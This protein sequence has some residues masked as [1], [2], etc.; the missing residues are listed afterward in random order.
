MA[1]PSAQANDNTKGRHGMQPGAA[2]SDVLAADYRALEHVDQA[3]RQAELE[4]LMAHVQRAARVGPRPEVIFQ[5][6]LTL[7]QQSRQLLTGL[8]EKFATRH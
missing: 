7:R 2:G 5:Q 4:L 8:G 3:L 1:Q 6:V